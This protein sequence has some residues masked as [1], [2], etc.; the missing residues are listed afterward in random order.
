MRTVNKLFLASAAVAASV[1]VALAAQP[2][3][4]A[5][6]S[7]DWPTFGGNNARLNS[8]TAPTKITAANVGSVVRQQVQVSAPIDAGLI[9]LK[10]VQVNGAAR[11]VFFG[12]TNLGRTVAIDA[13]EGKVL[14]EY[15]S[16]GF[17]ET[18]AF[19]GGTPPGGF[20]S[21]KQITNS[22]PVADANRQ[23]I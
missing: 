6:A 8:N 11:D 5:G 1:A 20:I 17:D 7:A 15:A 14:W 19:V 18:A 16:P 23:F 12:T 13:N 2:A 4:P 9:Y 10:G 3:A 21:V 22:T